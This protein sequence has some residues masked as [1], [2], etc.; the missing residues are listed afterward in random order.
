MALVRWLRYRY[1]AFT[2]IELLVVIAIIAV[3]IGLLLPA[4]Q[5]VRETANRL[6]CANNLKQLGI[7]MHNFHDTNL[8]FPTGGGS[9][10]DGP[11]YAPN[12]TPYGVHMQTAGFHYQLLPFIEQDALYRLPDYP[13][14]S[15]SFPPAH[16][17]DMSNVGAF[18]LKTFLVPYD[19][20]G[21][22][23]NYHGDALHNTT[24]VKLFLCPS[25]RLNQLFT[26][27]W[28]AV[29][30]DYAAVVP[31]P[32]FPPPTNTSL[33]DEFWGPFRGTIVPGIDGNYNKATPTTMASI[34]DGTSNTIALAEK[35]MP[36]WSY[37]DWWFGDDKGAFHGFDND[38]FRSTV[39][40]PKVAYFNPHG[41]QLNNPMRDFRVPQDGT[42]WNAGFLFGSA[43]PAGI[44]CLFTDGS[45]RHMPYSIDRVVFSAL[46]NREDG[47]TIDVNF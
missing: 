31:S 38:N 9:W 45:V 27:S 1:T 35:F 33:E 12:R 5:K 7:A 16:C 47:A 22:D 15:T 21:N 6:S 8:V 13:A 19:R 25:R 4:V 28:R 42:D 2:L 41:T 44:N 36:I 34:R 32:S 17:L 11:S 46:G 39:N 10:N 18:P 3:L 43:H 23:S 26:N 20:A 14:T 40:N 29:K 30:N 24:G 37:D